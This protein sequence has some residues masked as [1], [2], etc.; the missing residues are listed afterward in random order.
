VIFSSVPVEI[1]ER[2]VVLEVG[3]RRR[4]IPNDFVWVLAGGTAPNE[5]LQRIGVQ[6]G[7]HDLTAEARAEVR[8]TA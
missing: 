4:E 2:T 7:S 3:G 6:L 1:R 5:F 8:R